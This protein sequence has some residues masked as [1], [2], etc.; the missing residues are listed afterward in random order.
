VSIAN[1]AIVGAIWNV[2]SRLG[3]RVVGLIATLV[4]TRFISPEVMGEVGVAIVAVATAHFASDLAFGQY[5]VVKSK[6]NQSAVFHALIF[7]LIAVG[8]VTLALLLLAGPVGE[9]L[10]ATEMERYAPVMAMAMVFERIG[11]I[12]ASIALRDL[13]FKL[14]ASV[15]AISELAYAAVAVIMAARGFGGDSI[16]WANVAQWGLWALWLGLAVKPG[17]W[18]KPFAITLRETKKLLNFGVPIALSNVAH[19]ASYNWDRLI[20][21]HL[22]G[23]RVHGIYGLGKRLSAVPADNVGDAVSDVLIPSFVRM[24]PEESRKAV[25]RACHLVAII[26]YPMA[27]GLAAVSPTLVHT[28]FTPEWYEIA[29]PLTI[30]AAVSLIDPLGDTMTSYL[31]ARD[32]PWS[33]ML[34]QVSFLA[35]LLGSIYVLGYFFGLMGACLG[36]GVG[37]FYRAIAGLYIAHLRDQV[38]MTA[39]LF[40]LVRVALAA[41]VMALSVVAVREA[42]TGALESVHLALAI[43]IAV[44]AVSYPI[45]AFALAGPIAREVVRWIRAKRAGAD[46]SSLLEE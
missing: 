44:G 40:G 16:V 42:F 26:V 38:S 21:T 33:V 10:G 2:A 31:K 37:M 39:M 34:V 25:V 20:I 41:G 1:T 4:I 22:F 36:V 15:S 28:L 29:M 14:F 23:A 46:P 30:L 19:D 24:G 3:A 9:L 11:R 6:D 13:R 7:T 43:E 45:A 35:V 18:L 27:A 8:V 5:V 17:L 12:P 32:M